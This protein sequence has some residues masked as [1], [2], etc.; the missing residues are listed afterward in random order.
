MNS[1]REH[2]L[3]VIAVAA[4]VVLLIAAV[5]RLSAPLGSP[6]LAP[7]RVPA[8]LVA[9]ASPRPA[10]VQ[11]ATKP[12]AKLAAVPSKRLG[13]RATPPQAVKPRLAAAMFRA[14][15]MIGR[16]RVAIVVHPGK[17][18]ALRSR[19]ADSP[20]ARA[21][22]RVAARPVIPMLPAAFERAAAKRPTRP[23]VVIGRPARAQ[24][25]P[26]VRRIVA[27]GFPMRR[28]GSHHRGV[29][30]HR[31]AAVEPPLNYRPE[32]ILLGMNAAAQTMASSAP[33][34]VIRQSGRRRH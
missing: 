9:L 26:A 20:I 16:S 11:G 4:G 34:P 18:A 28:G 13:K 5:Y 25:A 8:P 15:S 33:F 14:E 17:T 27:F 2:G 23:V 19:V 21:G 1:L 32:P 3:S 7:Q 29:R 10:P 30:L 24:D 12:L 6:A 22:P 31:F